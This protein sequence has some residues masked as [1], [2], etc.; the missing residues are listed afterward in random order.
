MVDLQ[1][2]YSMDKAQVKDV[3]VSML[4][5]HDYQVLDGLGWIVARP[6]CISSAQSS[7]ALVSHMDIAGSEAPLSSEIYFDKEQGVIRL[8]PHA[9]GVL[10]ADDKNGLWSIAKVI[11]GGARPWVIL[12][13]MEESGCIGAQMLVDYVEN[14]GYGVEFIVQELLDN[15]STLV[16]IDR[17]MHEGKEHEAV[18][19]TVQ[20]D[21][22]IQYVESHDY[23]I[24]NGSYSDIA[25]LVD[26]F[27]HTLNA[28][29]LNAGY[30]H[31]HTSRE[32]TVV[33]DVLYTVDQVMDMV[34]NEDGIP[35]PY[36]TD[37]R[38]TTQA[39]RW[40]GD[41]EDVDESWTYD[42]GEW[43]WVESYEND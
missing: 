28:V 25:V 34:M 22:F 14:Y 1:D 12:T 36:L 15:V 3:M 4:Q 38:T 19:Y 9:T 6:E 21:E 20:S 41:Y 32:Y 7:V 37:V 40:Y 16:E 39:G 13:D 26:M 33:N 35:S 18:F 11:E 42:D 24:V 43:K 17:G 23:N 5:R 30:V 27:S 31:E 2:F 10:G 8:Q 29:N